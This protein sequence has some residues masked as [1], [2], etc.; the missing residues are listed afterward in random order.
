[1]TDKELELCARVIRSAPVTTKALKEAENRLW[2][3]THP[4][5]VK[6]RWMIHDALKGLEEPIFDGASD[7]VDS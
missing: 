2:H 3:A 4:N 1:M 6:L 5:A 7:R